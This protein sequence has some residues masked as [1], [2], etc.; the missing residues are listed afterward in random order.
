MALRNLPRQPS[1]A[2]YFLAEG[3]AVHNVY[4]NQIRNQTL[5]IESTGPPPVGIPVAA[6]LADKIVVLHEL[7]KACEPA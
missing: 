1:F 6:T 5:T 7:T 2:N 4:P 3:H